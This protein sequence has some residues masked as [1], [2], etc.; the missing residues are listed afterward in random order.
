MVE[1][2]VKAIGG[3]IKNQNQNLTSSSRPVAISMGK[4]VAL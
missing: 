1:R 2:Y 4:T 3:H